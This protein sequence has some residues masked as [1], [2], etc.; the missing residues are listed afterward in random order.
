MRNTLEW[1]SIY[2][3]SVLYRKLYSSNI[4]LFLGYTSPQSLTQKT[5]QKV[6]SDKLLQEIF[7]GVCLGFFVWGFLFVHLFLLVY[8]SFKTRLFC[9]IVKWCNE[10]FPTMVILDLDVSS[11]TPL[12][13]FSLK[14][15]RHIFG[16]NIHTTKHQSLL[17]TVLTWI[18]SQ[19]RLIQERPESGFL[20]FWVNALIASFCS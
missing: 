13:P 10:T 7:E 8:H 17:F 12:S 15:E 20:N 5:L 6:S 3:L 9:R 16:K 14:Q 2:R 19:V 18:K 1:K 11:T 4:V